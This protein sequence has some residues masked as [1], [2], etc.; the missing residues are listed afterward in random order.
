MLRKNLRRV[1]FLVVAI[2]WG[3]LIFWLSS[4][5]DLSSGLPTIYDLI[6]RKLAHIT[7]YAVLAYLVLNIFV[8]KTA[9]NLFFTATVCIIYAITDEWHQS[10]IAGRSGDPRDVMIDT[11]GILLSLWAYQQDWLIKFFQRTKKSRP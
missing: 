8:K 4:V 6:L 2:L 5:P 11:I 9:E 1:Y 10:F 3:Y 7:A